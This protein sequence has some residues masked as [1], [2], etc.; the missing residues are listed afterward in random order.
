MNYTDA[1]ADWLYEDETLADQ[2]HPCIVEITDDRIEI[3]YDADDGVFCH[4][5]GQYVEGGYSQLQ[6]INGSGQGAMTL[7]L[8][9]PPLMLV[10]TWS[11][12]YADHIRARGMF[13]ITLEPDT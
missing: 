3:K 5:R 12:T 6:R 11:E 8:S 13:Q 2:D 9:P 4:W 7:H 10:G 1:L